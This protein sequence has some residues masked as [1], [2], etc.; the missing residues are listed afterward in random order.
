MIRMSILQ[1]KKIQRDYESVENSRKKKLPKA[2]KEMEKKR[3]R[4]Y[5]ILLIKLT[6]QRRPYCLLHITNY[7]QLL[8]NN[9]K[10]I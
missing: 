5:N 4:I 6:S 9:N 2:Y 7:Y 10:Y 3:T 1:F 8:P